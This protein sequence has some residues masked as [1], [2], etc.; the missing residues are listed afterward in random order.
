MGIHAMNWMIRTFSLGTLSVQE[1]NWD[2][3]PGFIP[4][5]PSCA[6]NDNA[7]REVLEGHLKR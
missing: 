5:K 7:I 2:K 4:R 1:F 3:M 6:N